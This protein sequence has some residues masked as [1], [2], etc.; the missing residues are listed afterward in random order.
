MTQPRSQESTLT[1]FELLK[2]ASGEAGVAR[3]GRLAFAGGR[4]TMQTPN[5]I[6]VASRGVV[7]HLTPDNVTKHTTFDAS[8]LA[9]EDFLE[10]AQPP[11]LQLPPGTP[12]NLQSFTAFPSDRAL[13][14]GPRRF[15]AVVTPVGN[16][17]HHVSIFTSTGFRKLT[18]PEFAKTI[19]LTQPDI[20]IPPA[21]LFHSSNT[22][23]SK[24]QI[25]MVERTEEWVDKF[26][27]ILD[28]K[29]RLKDMGVSVFA[30]VLP[31][32]Y[33]IQWDY[34]RY[35]AEDVRDSLSG[36]A[37]YD[38]N[39]VPEL[40]N[41]PSLGDLP[42]L[43]FGPSKS[44]QDLLRQVALG[45]D[46]CTVPFANTASDAGI[47]LLFTFTPPESSNLQPLGIDMWSEEHTTSL[48]PLV[49]GCQCY[50][51]TKH[52]R[53]FIK[54]LLNAKEMLGWSLLQIHNHAILSAFFAGIREALS[55]STEKFEELHKK[56]LAVY[57]PEIPIGT[58]QRPRARGYHF[59]SIAGQTKINE[60][61][62]QLYD[63]VD[64]SPHPEAIAE[65]LAA[66]EGTLPI[67]GVAP[68]LDK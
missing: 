37:V 24:R 36:L 43:S 30:P 15:P 6:A 23:S 10:K 65:P 52:H 67:D 22:P 35:L 53:A 27:H 42:R 31:V 41:Y 20:A 33:P 12:R 55:E 66:V 64:V 16:T 50:T 21:D 57:E 25:R 3:L 1:M 54:H 46:V 62:W 18:I 34:L 49:D 13:V 11:V 47:A 60:P 9:I 29:G 40:V 63:S 58:G 45:I 19:E 2:P 39:L 61:S 68:S 48:Q 8:Y 17:D 38:V 7:P 5:Y 59:K 51:C 26:F 56:F 14:L 32:E 28:P 4:R 44:P